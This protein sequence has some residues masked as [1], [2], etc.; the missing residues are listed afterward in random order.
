[1]NWQY[2]I[3]LFSFLFL[4]SCSDYKTIHIYGEPY[5]I[6]ILKTPAERQ[7]GLTGKFANVFGAFWNLEKEEKY[8]FHG[9]GLEHEIKI[10]FYDDKKQLIG[11]RIIVPGQR[12]FSNEL[13]FRYVIELQNTAILG[14][15]ILW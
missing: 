15:A 11:E 3:I 12:P 13:P 5:K 8:L 2:K 10:F 7:T 1:M 14:G 9:E 4:S 6:Q